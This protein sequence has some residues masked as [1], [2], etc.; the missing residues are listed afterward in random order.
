ML[1]AQLL[2]WLCFL[3]LG[4]ENITIEVVAHVRRAFVNH[5]QVKLSLACK[6]FLVLPRK[7]TPVVLSRQIPT[8][9]SCL[10]G[11]AF[12]Y[13]FSQTATDILCGDGELDVQG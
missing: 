7:L 3:I 2:D 9:S 10:R 12:C 8:R 5:T 13:I 1:G 11:Y 6:L 4:K